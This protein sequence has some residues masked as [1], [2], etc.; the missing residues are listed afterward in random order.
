MH[1]R[2]TMTYL[3]RL[4]KKAYVELLIAAFQTTQGNNVKNTFPV[5]LPKDCT[6]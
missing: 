1:T 5:Q 3:L 2:N 6:L 4:C